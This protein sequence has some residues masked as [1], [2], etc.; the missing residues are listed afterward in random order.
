MQRVYW[1]VD[2]LEAHIVA[3][4]LRDEGIPSWVFDEFMIRQNWLRAL[5]IGGY[6]VMTDANAAPRAATLVASYLANTDPQYADGDM[7]SCP[8]CGNHA[9]RDDPRPRR[10][11][12]L[13]LIA[14][15][16]LTEA[17]VLWSAAAGRA[18]TCL[19]ALALSIIVT[20]PGVIGFLVKHRYV[21]ASCARP[22]RDD[23]GTDY[24]A[25]AASVA[26]AEGA[27]A[28]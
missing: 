16:W 25:L 13:W 24:R 22:F 14:T 28:S 4:S 7:P 21:C 11:V 2:F 18:V 9:V 15:S 27:S 5:A 20:L 6:R 8:R 3:G 10:A 17:L 23:R 26:A 1:T 19:V 12:F